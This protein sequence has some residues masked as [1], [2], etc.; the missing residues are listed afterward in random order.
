MSGRL[1]L[2][3]VQCLALRKSS[4]LLRNLLNQEKFG[5]PGAANMTDN[6][7]PLLGQVDA[8]GLVERIGAI[9]D[10]FHSQ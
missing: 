5:C 1:S 9:L 4:N 2:G 3:K 6:M 10:S 7:P 8:D